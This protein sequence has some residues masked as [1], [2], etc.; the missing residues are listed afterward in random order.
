[1]NKKR[2]I[3]GFKIKEYS[4]KSLKK[5]YSGRLV[6]INNANPKIMFNKYLKDK[7]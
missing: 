5:D 1:M 3:N 6:T 4:N 7:K 2:T